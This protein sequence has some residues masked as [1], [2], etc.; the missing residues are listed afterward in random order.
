MMVSVSVE[1]CTRQFKVKVTH[2]STRSRSYSLPVSDGW[3]QVTNGSQC[4]HGPVQGAEVLAG[5]TGK[6]AFR[7][8]V[9]PVVSKALTLRDHVVEHGEPMGTEE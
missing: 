6:L 9:S 3:R 7:L 8:R 2:R 5:D 4:E 1:Q